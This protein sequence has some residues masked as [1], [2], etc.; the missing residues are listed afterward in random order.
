[1]KGSEAH[2]KI[3]LLTAL[4]LAASIC[5]FTQTRV[6]PATTPTSNT[7]QELMRLNQE[8]IDALARGDKSAAGR[9][10]ADDFVRITVQG[11]VLTK[12]QVLE[13][14]KAPEAGVKIS[15][16]SKDIKVFDYGDAAVLVYLSIRHTD[17][18]G[19]K[20]DFLY[21]VTDTFVIRGG[22]W[23]KAASAGTPIPKETTMLK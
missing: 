17:N 16:E 21:R 22:R 7:E 10:Y 4:M 6:E 12:A 11:G 13:S 1:L 9:I 14:L 23:V 3:A 18:N 2:M 5:V 19:E 15:Y 8:L 20:S